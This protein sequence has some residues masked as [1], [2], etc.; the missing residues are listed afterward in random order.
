MKK[1]EAK[2][3]VWQLTCGPSRLDEELWIIYYKVED[4]KMKE[5]NWNWQVVLE[6]GGKLLFKAQMAQIE[7][8]MVINGKLR[9]FPYSINF[10]TKEIVIW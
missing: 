7:M 3:L 10:E 6:Y 5:R 9:K 2:K 1:K 8:A 4:F